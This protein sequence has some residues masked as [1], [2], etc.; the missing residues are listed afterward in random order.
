MSHLPA[1]YATRAELTLKHAWLLNLIERH[2][3]IH[4]AVGA[5]LKD[6]HEPK[7]MKT[8]ALACP[9]NSVKLPGQLAYVESIA[10]GEADRQTVTRPG[11]FIKR[12]FPDLADDYVRDKVALMDAEGEKIEIWREGRLI[13]KAA[14]EGP[15]SCMK[16][17]GHDLDDWEEHPYAAYDPQYGWGVAVQMIGGRIW[18]RAL[19]LDDGDNKCFV[20]SFYQDPDGEAYSNSGTVIEA[21]LKE[22]GYK[23]VPD[24]PGGTR[25]ARLDPCSSD[26]Q[27]LAPY[28]DGSNDYVYDRGDY[29]EITTSGSYPA[30]QCTSTDGGHDR[31]EDREECD[32]CGDMVESE[33]LTWTL[34]GEG[35]RVCSGCLNRYTYLSNYGYVPDDDIE[36]VRARTTGSTISWY[37][38]SDDGIPDDVVIDVDGD[39]LHTDDAIWIESDDG[40]YPFDHKRIVQPV[41]HEDHILKSDAVVVGG[42][43]FHPDDCIKLPDG[44]MYPEAEATELEDGTWVPDDD[45]VIRA[46]G[47]YD[48]RHAVEICAHDQKFYPPVQMN[49]IWVDGRHYRVFEGNDTTFRQ[50]QGIPTP[51]EG[52]QPLAA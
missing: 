22:M 29:L 27:F 37:T 4:P 35:G 16:W 39:Y 43:Y 41:G 50:K 47:E 25:L 48:S 51:D 46:D 19:V 12:H 2:P 38:N 30:I 10:K 45:V 21:W 20:R 26:Y 44:S 13:V 3:S 5:V 31:V 17:S 36:T 32:D 28:L 14:L 1:Y 42:R 24:W 9:Y 52:S 33:E 34:D 18:G 7:C 49:D 15:K 8:L 23:H 40:Y 6:G 11:R